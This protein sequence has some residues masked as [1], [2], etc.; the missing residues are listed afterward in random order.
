M[1]L[2]AHLVEEFVLKFL[3]I[4]GTQ[5]RQVQSL[6][7]GEVGGLQGLFCD[8][9]RQKNQVPTSRVGAVV[10]GPAHDRAARAVVSAGALA[11]QRMHVHDIAW[12]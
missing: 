7:E 9:L 1:Q 5:A 12:L 2:H 3:L 6:R 8:V 11:R 4:R 10:S